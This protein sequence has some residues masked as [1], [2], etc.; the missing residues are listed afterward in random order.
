[1]TTARSP[2]RKLKAQADEIAARL[3]AM[4]RGEPSGVADPAGKVAAARTR[5]SITFGV[6]M[7]DKILKIKMPWATLKALSEAGISE[8]ILKHMR[9]ARD[10]VH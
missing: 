1:M 8:W 5:E 4:E 3:K 6:V 9:E 7:D 2:L 10:P